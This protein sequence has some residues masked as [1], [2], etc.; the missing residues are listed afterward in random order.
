M[1]YQDGTENQEKSI[2]PII[3]TGFMGVQSATKNYFFFAA[4]F[5]FAGF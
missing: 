5:G 1:W 4:I 2:N 3:Y